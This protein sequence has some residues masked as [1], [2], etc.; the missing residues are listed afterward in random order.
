MNLQVLTDFAK[1]LFIT[2]H[3]LFAFLWLN[4]WFLCVLNSIHSLYVVPRVPMSQNVHWS[5]WKYDDLS[6]NEWLFQYFIESKSY[7]PYRWLDPFFREHLFCFWLSYVIY[8]I[9]CQKQITSLIHIFCRCLVTLH[10]KFYV[11]IKLNTLGKSNCSVIPSL[12]IPIRI[13]KYY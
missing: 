12:C 4:L 7:S 10:E 13:F 3:M 5:G 8:F 9:S 11:I 2:F 6:L 1:L